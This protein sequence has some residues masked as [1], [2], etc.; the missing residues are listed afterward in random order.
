[1]TKTY[2]EIFNKAKTCQTN[3]KKEYKTGMTSRW[4][5][6][7]AKAILTPKKDI[8]TIT[9]K[10]ATNPTGTHISRQ[11]SK[12]DYIDICKRLVKYVEK[13]NQMPNYVTYKTYKIKPR[14]LTIVI[15]LHSFRLFY[16]LLLCC[17]LYHQSI[18]SNGNML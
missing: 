8:K 1:M 17:F 7:F 2:K 9:I 18:L 10:E 12:T 13:H 4:S 5:Y 6:Y 14:L 11:I 16:L 15:S 3:V